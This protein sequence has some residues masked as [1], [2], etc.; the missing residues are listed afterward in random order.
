MHNDN[1]ICLDCKV[2]FKGGHFCPNCG[3]VLLK[4]S[5][6]IRVP[7]KRDKKGWIKFIKWIKSFSQYTR[8]K[9]HE[10]YGGSV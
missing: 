6:K 4:A 1:Q 8:D 10:I 2:A 3:K 7:K 5:H 9:I